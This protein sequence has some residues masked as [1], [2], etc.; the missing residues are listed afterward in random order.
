MAEPTTFGEFILGLEGLAIL[1][2]WIVDAD[3]VKAR[4]QKIVEM[5]GRLEEQPWS[6][7]MDRV[8][9][10]VTDGYAEW[11]ATYDT[12]GNP[13]LLAEEPVVRE[14]LARYPAGTALDAACGTGRYASYM[15]SLGH[16]VT[17]IDASPEMLE[18]AAMKVPSAD[19]NNAELASIPLPDGA[20]DIA[21]CTLALTHCSDLGPPI[22]ELS[23]VVRSGGTI[24]I[25]D[26]HPFV[27]MLGGQGSYR[28]NQTELR[29]V[30]NFLHWPSDYLSAFQAVGLSVVQ[31]IEPLWG[32][33]EISMMGFAEQMPD[34]MDAS[35]KG[36]P[37]VI[38]WE[39]QKGA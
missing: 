1:R 20:V 14:L 34:L 15:A 17:G 12:S 18:V 9:R 25:S 13:I 10:S 31:C 19:F 11:A 37:I 32:D 5:A 33:R 24:V 28:H 35:V 16:R 7:P 6:N 36:V 26:V 21:V 38:V 23:R 39:L 2:S 8:E 4:T 27:V 29:F 22:R 3:T 30:R